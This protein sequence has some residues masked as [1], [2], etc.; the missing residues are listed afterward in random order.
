M[1][2]DAQT[3]NRGAS[4]AVEELEPQT[5]PPP[6][7]DTLS[8]IEDDET[9]CEELML[10]V[11]AT[12]Q[13]MPNPV[14]LED[15]GVIARLCA[16]PD[17][18]F[19]PTLIALAGVDCLGLDVLYE[20]RLL[21]RMAALRRGHL[22]GTFL[23][24]ARRLPSFV[25]RDFLRELRR[26][27]QTKQTTLAAPGTPLVVSMDT[28]TRTPVTWLWWPYIAVG[29]L[30]LVD[31][32]PGVGKSLFL[33]QLAAS[34]SRGNPLPDQDGV[35]TLPSGG[36]HTT[37]LL[38]TEDGLADTLGP[39]LDA[40]GADSSKVKVLTGWVDGQ[41]EEHAFTFQH[42]GLLERVLQEYQ[43]T[44]VVIDPI[45]AYLGSR[46][47]MHRANE[48]RPLLEALRRLADQYHCAIV[49]VR[50][51]AKASQGSKAI[52]RGLGSIDFI[53]AGRTGLFIEQ[54]PSDPTLVLMA[55]SKSNIGPL[56]RTQVFSKAE[57]QFRWQGVSRLSAEMLAGAGRGPDPYAF[58]EAVCWLED[59]LQDG[60][61]V[62]S[63]DLCREADEEGLTFSTLRR[64]KKALGVRSL[65]R[66]DAWDWQLPSRRVVPPPELLRSLGS[67]T[68]CAPLEPL[69]G[70]QAVSVHE[71]AWDST[72]TIP[73][74][75]ADACPPL[76]E[77]G[78]EDPPDAEESGLAEPIEKV[79]D[80]Q[81]AH[82]M[83]APQAPVNGQHNPPRFCPRCHRLATWRMRDGHF[84]C[85]H[86]SAS[87]R[88]H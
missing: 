36:A 7:T 63:T 3:S 80:V 67:L 2:E 57:G 65:K 54:H 6:Y 41:G 84:V 48:T 35:P 21:P 28:V 74:A 18:H 50:H 81:D 14:P 47:D 53:G 29:K 51:P 12:R 24:S 17:V 39:R 49:C 72:H 9:F 71:D 62:P 26:I 44:L 66:G 60:L 23:P 82:A 61:P 88:G 75:P 86:C 55:Q 34:L 5:P 37:V 77:P 83:Q 40:A 42:M 19:T 13:L 58:L 30:A 1:P 56:G 20:E 25:E 68:P 43:P 69:Q 59:R 76:R 70:N 78:E 15:A 46:V 8:Q 11:R 33:T 64:A 38:S 73:Q 87:V 52:H 16:L 4:T 45:Q 10:W 22:R 79:E 31:G 85:P 27:Q 32:D